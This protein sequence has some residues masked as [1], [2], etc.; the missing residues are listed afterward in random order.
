MPTIWRIETKHSRKG[1]FDSCVAH[2]IWPRGN[3]DHNKIYNH[4][5]PEIDR[6]L[7]PHWNKM[8]YMD[9]R[10]WFFGFKDIVQ[11]FK[12]FDRDCRVAMSEYDGDDPLVLRK[13]RVKKIIVGE[14]QI[15]FLKEAGMELLEER[16]P[17]E[18]NWPPL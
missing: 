2:T 4:P 17:L 10:K 18:D 15:V 9:R 7:S 8:Y 11:Y 1:M 3:D 16:D 12:C 5:S 6:E 13:Y 14:F